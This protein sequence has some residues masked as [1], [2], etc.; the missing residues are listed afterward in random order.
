[1]FLMHYPDPKPDTDVDILLRALHRA[2][3]N[4]PNR[5]DLE[6]YWEEHHYSRPFGSIEEAEMAVQ[7]FHERESAEN[8]IWQIGWNLREKAIGNHSFVRWR[9]CKKKI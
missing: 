4:W 7:K 9:S 8:C 5:E 2:D 1:M 6:R 3:Q